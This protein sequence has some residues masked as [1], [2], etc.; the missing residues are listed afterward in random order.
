MKFIYRVGDKFEDP[1]VAI[2]CQDP[3]IPSTIHIIESIDF[4]NKTIIL[5]N[6]FYNG[7]LLNG[8][9]ANLYNMIRRKRWI[10]IGI[11][12]RILEEILK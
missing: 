11:R 7:V 4:K 1:R 8:S 12:K 10:P 3:T 2:E 5:E 9:F 6:Y